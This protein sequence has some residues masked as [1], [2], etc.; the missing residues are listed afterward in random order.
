MCSSSHVRDVFVP[1]VTGLAYAFDHKNK[2]DIPNKA[3]SVMFGSD[4]IKS[5]RPAREG[6]NVLMIILDADGTEVKRFF[7]GTPSVSIPVIE[8]LELARVSLEEELPDNPNFLDGKLPNPILRMTGL[9][10]ECTISFFGKEEGGFFD[11]L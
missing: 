10:I 7:P 4:N 8:V 9:E 2:V 5:Y 1:G 11:I 3:L 6:D